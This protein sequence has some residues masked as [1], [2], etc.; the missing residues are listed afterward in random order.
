MI[1][2]SNKMKFLPRIYR[3]PLNYKEKFKFWLNPKRKRI[4]I[5]REPYTK[6]FRQEFFTKQNTD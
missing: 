1:W 6:K 4:K 5:I 3:V 2:N